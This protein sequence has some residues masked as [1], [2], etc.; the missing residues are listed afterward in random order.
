MKKIFY[1]VIVVV[2]LWSCKSKQEEINLSVNDSIAV[3]ITEV[4]S[5]KVETN[6]RY[7]GTV[8]PSQ[9]IP[10]TFQTSGIIEKVL[11]DAGDEV[12]RGQL[13]ASVDKAD[14]QSIYNMNLAKYSQAKDAYDRLK[15]VY[16][17]GSLPEVKWVEMET[18]LQQAKSSLEVSKNTLEKCDMRAPEAGVI[19]K[20]NI[21]PGMSSIGISNAPL[22]LVQ[23]KTVYV[24]ISV[25]E[26]E[27]GK[28]GKGDKAS[29]SVSALNGKMFQ[30]VITNLS[31]VAD[32][33]SRTYA[34]KI[35]VQNS[36]MDLKPGMV[37]DVVLNMKTQKSLVLVPY[38]SVT[39][40]NDGKSYV[41]LVD[42]SD[43]KAYKVMVHTGN[44]QGNDIEILAGVTPGQ[45]IV[46]Q[47]KE[48]L[49]DNCLIR[50]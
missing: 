27:I 36:Q 46:K 6:L 39:S 44:Y 32:A 14:P 25:P 23:I 31:P 47:G 19:G 11:V 28:I 45:T 9:T 38:Q 29:F 43:K 26:N 37:C 5:E 18:N 21:E 7:S 33:I 40:D 20:R 49:S 48:K 8:E 50:F 24:K 34:A 1:P 22:E 42:K 16:E 35:T 17:K 13:L 41:F 15:T 30:G 2:V 12:N 10:L 4:R 3:I